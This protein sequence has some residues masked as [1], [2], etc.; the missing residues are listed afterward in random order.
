MCTLIKI[1][2]FCAQKFDHHKYYCTLSRDVSYVL[3]V[4]ANRNVLLTAYLPRFGKDD[5]MCYLSALSDEKFKEGKLEEVGTTFKT[6]WEVSVNNTPV[7][8]FY[9]IDASTQKAHCSKNIPYQQ[10]PQSVLNIFPAIF[11]PEDIILKIY[12]I[13]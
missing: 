2:T 7:F 4:L 9:I 3:R 8:V 12:V 13:F 11:G 5:K 10:Y 1:I 6:N